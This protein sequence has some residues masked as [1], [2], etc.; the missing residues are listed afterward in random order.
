MA[1]LLA[2]LPSASAAS[3]LR[4]AS[5]SFSTKIQ[6]TADFDLAADLPRTEV[7][8]SASLGGRTGRSSEREMLFLFSSATFGGG[9]LRQPAVSIT[10]TKEILQNRFM[11][12]NSCPGP[13]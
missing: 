6:S 5:V 7:S 13:H 11:A 2:I 1:P 10:N 9:G 12:E 8:A 4:A 3:I